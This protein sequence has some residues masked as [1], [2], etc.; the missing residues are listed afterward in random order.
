M[1]SLHIHANHVYVTGVN[2][3]VQENPVWVDTF[4]VH[5][6][7]IVE[8]AVPFTRPPDVPN[9]RG[10]GLADKPLDSI[11]NPSIS[12]SVPHPVWPPEEEMNMHFPKIGNEGWKY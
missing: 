7:D 2:G 12:G 4:T 9:E 1:H 3:V 8:W 10:I 11:P 5:P 6:L